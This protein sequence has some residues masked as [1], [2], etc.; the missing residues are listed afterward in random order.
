MVVKPQKEDESESEELS[1]K[2]NMIITI[3]TCS[4]LLMH[5][6]TATQTQVAYFLTDEISHPTSES[7]RSG[8][9]AASFFDGFSDQLTTLST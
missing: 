9:T 4:C 5:I 6:D 1:P 7:I 8:N 3:T 2:P